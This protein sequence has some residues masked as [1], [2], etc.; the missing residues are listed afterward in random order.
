MGHWGPDARPGDVSA[1]FES[2]DDA[3]R[4][5]CMRV[6]A[7]SSLS[8]S[9]AGPLAPRRVGIDDVGA[10]AD[11]H[12][13]AAAVHPETE[14]L[15][16]ATRRTRRRRGK[17]VACLGG[18]HRTPKTAMGKRGRERGGIGVGGARRGGEER[19]SDAATADGPLGSAGD[20]NEGKKQWGGGK[21]GEGTYLTGNTC[22]A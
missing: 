11:A 10:R 17:R 7:H 15:S 9:S 8:P 22:D 4:P 6:P 14:D 1:S 13:R 18:S 2:D 21:G 20:D 3:P 5:P 19:R 16:A 12:L